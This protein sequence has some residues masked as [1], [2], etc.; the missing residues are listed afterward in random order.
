M[1]THSHTMMN[2]HTH[3]DSHN[4]PTC[5]KGKINTAVLAALCH[6]DPIPKSAFLVNLFGLEEGASS[7]NGDCP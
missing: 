4:I 2:V 5:L 1:H 3:T 6:R 7:G